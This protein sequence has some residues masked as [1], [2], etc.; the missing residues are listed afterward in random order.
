MMFNVEELQ[1][2]SQG[3]LIQG[4]SSARVKGV[5]INSRAIKKGEVFIAIPGPNFDGHDFVTDAIKKKAAVVIVTK[6][7]KRIP[8]YIPVIQVKDTV[9]ALG[10][11]ARAFRDRF[12][13]PV[14]AI[15][16]SA[17][18]TTTKEMLAY[19][20]GNDFNV[21]KNIKTENNH[22]GVPLTLLK[23]KPKHEIAVIELGTNRPKDIRWLTYIVN[24]QVAILTNIGE[25]HL[26]LLKSPSGVFQEK[27]DLV[28]GMKEGGTVI[29]N[30]D[31]VYLNKIP[32]Y[33]FAHKIVKYAIKNKAD[34]QAGAIE[35]HNGFLRFS[36]NGKKG[37]RLRTLA[38]HNIYNAL[39][40]ISCG[41][42]FKMSEL[43]IQKRLARFRF[44][45]GR[46]NVG[47]VGG[48]WLI[49]D[50]YNA[51][52]VSLRSALQTLSSLN[53]RGRK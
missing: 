23:L 3:K 22:I 9:K 13:I 2:A 51:N 28:S 18:K 21:L 1:K 46:Q 10:K 49:D 42:Q 12:S 30:A 48:C 43:A 34:Y 4:K 50:T 40:A 53:V 41:K 38:Q 33:R 17:G 24:P 32:S 8:G 16:G 31:D 7:L 36:V 20:L 35:N 52:P 29:F 45:A 5:S 14:I 15:T 37:W 6:N 27:F 26:E 39:V 44:P 19:T 11:I 47:K 25:S